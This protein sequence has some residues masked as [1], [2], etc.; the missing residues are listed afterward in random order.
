M[1]PAAILRLLL[2]VVIL[3][4]MGQPHETHAQEPGPSSVW[5]FDDVAPQR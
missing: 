1:E 3:V 5:H 4:A 2:V